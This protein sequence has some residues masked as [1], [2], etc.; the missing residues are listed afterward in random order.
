MKRNI[1]Y[2]SM[3][4]V[5]CTAVHAN[6]PVEALIL[7][8]TEKG[9]GAIWAEKQSA[10]FKEF[11]AVL[12]NAGKKSVDLSKVCYKLYDASGNSYKLDT[13]DGKITAGSLDPGESVEGFYQFTSAS[14]DV[15]TANLVKV[16]GDCK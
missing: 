7:Y 11:D 2:A 15:Y 16:L 6:E 1:V 5:F 10:Y 4:C 13:V 12:I 8:S 3:L 14:E 9:Q